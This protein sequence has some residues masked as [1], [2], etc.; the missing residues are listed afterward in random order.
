MSSDEHEPALSAAVSSFKIDQQ[1]W[2]I[3]NIFHIMRTKVIKIRK[4]VETFGEQYATSQAKESVWKGELRR[5]I[6]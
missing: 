4:M 1:T 5:N 2:K 3:E 6:E